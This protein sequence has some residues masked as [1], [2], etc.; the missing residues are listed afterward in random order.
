MPEG[1]HFSRGLTLAPSYSM[2]R[3]C[4]ENE[5]CLETRR[6]RAPLVL[7]HGPSLGA[8]VHGVV[9]SVGRFQGAG[10]RRA[11]TRTRDPPAT[12]P[13]AADDVDRPRFP[14]GRLLPRA[15]WRSFLITPA[16]LLAWHR[17]LVAKRWT[18]VRRPGRLPIR[19][20]IRALVL[21]LARDNPRWGYLRI[22]GELKGLGYPSRQRPC[23]RGFRHSKAT[24]TRATWRHHR[25]MRPRR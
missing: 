7:L 12:T 25:L 1:S 23:A 21:R 4:V 24:W 6:L 13:S 19:L 10:N 22:V 14:R 17:R 9:F 11:P 20:E 3:A 8:S 15:R 2:V 16:T 18:Y 5:G